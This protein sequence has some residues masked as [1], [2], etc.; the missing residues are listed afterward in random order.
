MTDC[1]Y[2]GPHDNRLS[3][4]HYLPFS[5]GRFRGCEPLNDRICIA[6]NNAI[7]NVEAQFL[8]SG[9]IG[10]FRW[11]LKIEGRN[12]LPPSPF[13]HRT[14]GASPL[15]MI[16]RVPPWPYD[17]LWETDPGTEEAFP[18]RQ[19]IF[20]HPLAGYHALPIFNWMLKDPETVRRELEER[21]IAMAKPIH[22]FADPVDIP[23][24]E[25]VFLRFGVTPPQDWCTTQLPPERIKFTINVSVTEAYFRAVAKIAFHYVLKV[26]PAFNGNEREFSGIKDF[27]WNGGK[28]SAFVRQLDGQFIANFRS[29]RVTN[30]MHIL[31]VTSSFKGIFVYAQFFVGPRCLPPPY[32]IFIGPN[33]S[34]LITRPIRKAH[35]F[36]IHHNKETSGFTGE[37]VD[38]NPANY[39]FTL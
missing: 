34:P 15:Y 19:I 36:V 38:A 22:A 31:A 9:P 32:Q 29:A 4:E 3:S 35:Q 37:M 5:L 21:G 2:P 24:L 18:L 1:I 39:I 8:R 17:I 16:A 23:H 27:I 20:E 6:C 13:Y 10:F 30:W 11:L 26:M 14:L 25:A 7:G 28:A 33:P 12:G